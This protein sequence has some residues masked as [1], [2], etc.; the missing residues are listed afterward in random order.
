MPKI[1][2]LIAEKAAKN[3]EWISYEYFPP[4]SEQGVANLEARFDRMREFAEPLFVDMTWGA[5]GSTSTLTLDL[6]LKLKALGLEPN[7]HLTCT[8]VAKEDVVS[9]LEAC[10]AADVR[11][12]VALRGDPPIGQEKWEAIEGGFTCALDLVRFIRAEHGD[13]F[14]LSVAGYPEG[15]PDVIVE[16]ESV[17]ELSESEKARCRV[18]DDGKVF[19]CRDEQFEAELAYL[20][21]KVDAG[22]DVVITQMFFDVGTYAAFVQACRQTGIMCPVVPGIMLLQAAAGF[23]KMTAFCKTRVPPALA[24]KV[25]ELAGDDAA[26]KAFGISYG[27]DMCNQLRAVNAPGLH[28]YTLNL[29]KSTLAIIDTLGL[30][31]AAATNAADEDQKKKYH[32]STEKNPGLVTFAALAVLVI[33]VVFSMRS[34]VRP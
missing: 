8:N 29:E 13:F 5:G 27:V 3:E 32:A 28:F 20:K 15:H 7:M 4:R 26:L 1:A 34:N 24:A 19:V 2:E 33:A 21:A 10:K 16:V 6:T 9:A 23:K 11:N 31:N 17:G 12:I 18:T 30:S 14:N 22:A 25:E